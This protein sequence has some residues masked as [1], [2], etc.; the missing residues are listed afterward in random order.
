VTRES[1][2]YTSVVHGEQWIV[3]VGESQVRPDVTA[4]MNLIDSTIEFG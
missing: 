2:A 4:Y 3:V 1:G